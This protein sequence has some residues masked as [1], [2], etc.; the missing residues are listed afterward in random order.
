MKNHYLSYP[1]RIL[2][3]R[4]E[5]FESNLYTLQFTDLKLQ[6]QFKFNTGQF[7]MA[8]LIGHGE[9]PF[10]ICSSSF[11]TDT[12]QLLVRKVGSVTRKIHELKKGDKLM[13]RGPYGHGFPMNQ[14][15][16][17]NLLLLGGGCGFVTMRTLILDYIKKP[18]PN[19]KIQVFFGVRSEKY[20]LFR[21]E[22]SDWEK[23][24]DFHL[25]VAE[26]TPKWKGHVGLITDLFNR[27]KLLKNVIALACGPPIM[28]RFSIQELKKIGVADEDIY[29]SFERRMDC[30]K[31]VCQH[32]AI[33]SYY[34]C[35]DGPVFS[36]DKIKD[37]PGAI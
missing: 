12:F 8:G 21:S 10:D 2:N 6:K 11:E 28:Y 18:N 5:N 1:A 31:G 24:I 32:C 34:V 15:A 36:Y 30:A 14:L 17:R 19:Q 20:A 25:I 4:K 37:I 3:I 7:V 26:P 27:V 35:K 13:V 23:H 9:A 33:G 29:L 16:E 22:F